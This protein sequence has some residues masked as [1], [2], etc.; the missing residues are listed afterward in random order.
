[1]PKILESIYEHI[2]TNEEKELIEKIKYEVSQLV[3]DQVLFEKL[4]SFVARFLNCD[5][6]DSRNLFLLSRD[7]TESI[8]YEEFKTMLS[9][10]N[11]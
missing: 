3:L 7:L 5:K 4:E 1:M 6:A 10:E 11:M 9:Q 8:L 2:K